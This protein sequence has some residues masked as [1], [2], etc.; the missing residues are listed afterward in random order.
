MMKAKYKSVV[1]K[2][3][4]VLAYDP[5][6]IVP[7]YKQI[8]IGKL[9]PLPMEPRRLNNLAYT[10][11]LTK[12]CMDTII[13]NI[14]NGFLLKDELELILH[15]IFKY[16]D[17]FAFTDKEQGTFSSKYYPHYIMRMV[18]HEPWRVPLIHLPHAKEAIIMQ[19]LEEQRLGRKYELSSSSYRSAFFTVEKKNGKLCIVH[20]LQPL[21]RVTI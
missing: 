11:K 3:V 14:L 16:E 13:G 20:D 8:E 12:E 21:N 4:P 19:M 17:T 7:E 9:S 15:V 5:H 6:S 10:K 1:K 2:V 18:P